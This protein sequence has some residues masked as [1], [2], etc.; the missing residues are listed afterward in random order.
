M[1]PIKIAESKLQQKNNPVYKKAQTTI[2]FSVSQ[3][4]PYCKKL[5]II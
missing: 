4:M 3:D 2:I 5:T 1:F